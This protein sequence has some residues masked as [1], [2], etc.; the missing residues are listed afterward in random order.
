MAELGGSL[1]TMH[2]PETSISL[3]RNKHGIPQVTADSFLDLYF[4]LGWVHAHDRFLNMELSRLVARGRGAECLNPALFA[5][6][7]NMRR[8]NLGSDAEKEVARLSI[9]SLALVDAYCSGVNRHIDEGRLPFEFKLIGHKPEPWVPADVITSLKLMGLIDLSETQAWMEKCII[10]MIRNGVGLDQLKELFPYLSDN[11]SPDHME[12]IRKV[13]LPEPII[14]ET[15]KWKELPRLQGSN[16]WAIA[17][18]KTRSGMPILCGDPHLDTSRLPAIWQEVILSCGHFYFVGA[19]VPG[20]PGLPLGRTNHLAWSPTYGNMDSFDYFMEEIKGGQCRRGDSYSPLAVREEIIK[21]RKGSPVK[22]DYYETDRGVLEETPDG[23]GCYLCLAWAQA[24]EC[25]AESIEGM[26]RIP[27]LNTVEE[28]GPVFAELDFGSFSWAMADSEGSIGFQM[29]GRCPVRKE[30]VS[31][32][33]PMPGWDDSFAWR[34]FHDRRK[35]PSSYNP[36]EGFVV[37][38]NNDLNSCGDLGPINLSMAPYRAGRIAQLLG[39][40]SDFDVPAMKKIQYD[41]Y[42]AQAAEFL[43]I[44]RPLIPGDENGILLAEWDCHYRS[45]SKAPALFERIY[46]ELIRIVFGELNFGR[47]VIDYLLEE[48]VLLHDYYWNF[49]RILL[50]ENSDW[51]KGRSRSEIFREAIA[52]GLSGEVEQYGSGRKIMMKHLMLGGRLPRFLKFDYGPVDIIGGRATVSLGQIFK[53]GER[54]ATFSPTYRFITDLAEHKAYSV[55]AGGP[56][57]RRFSP[58]YVSGMPGWISGEYNELVPVNSE[59]LI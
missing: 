24:K 47:E 1:L 30:G 32:L 4:A 58:W 15:V 19:T 41:L 51:F 37:T 50:S 46:E 52:R 21:V 18:H 17:G 34:G 14:P 25:G 28:A 44:I 45:T 26:L 43:P 49:D 33:L 10:Q 3:V 48:S 55:L 2:G 13:R 39:E 38:A 6:D 36:S 11:P 54:E 57:D 23:D 22:I 8:Y 29:S 9:D 42:S 20:I 40:R 59:Q 12:A 5:L 16:N 35:N 53:S 27:E 7:V 31:G 56:S